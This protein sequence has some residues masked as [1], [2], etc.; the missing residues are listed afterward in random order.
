MSGPEQYKITGIL[1][2]GGKSTRMGRDKGNIKIG[3]QLL[4]QYPLKVLESLCEN[5]FISTSSKSEY[6]DTHV[7]VCDDTPGIGPLGGI[8]TCLKKSDTD[9]NI[10][11][12]CDMPLVHQALFEY[13]LQGC[14]GYDVVVPA[15]SGYKPEPLCGIY[16]SSVT[17]ILARMISNKT[18]AVHEI[19]KLVKSKIVVI[20]QAMPFYTPSMFMNI[21]DSCDLD[22]LQVLINKSR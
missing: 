10:V 13:L 7:L 15:L 14:M 17:G 5:V 21:N 2:A 11:L 18:Y 1:L 9:L 6:P 3:N 4:Y 8:Y 20:S 16:R 19:F 22:H 12:S